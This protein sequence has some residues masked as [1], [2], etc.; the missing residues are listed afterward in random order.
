VANTPRDLA[1]RVDVVITMLSDPA[2]V[3]EVLE[4]ADGILSA[5][6]QGLTLIDMSTVGPLDAR[7]TVQRAAAHG[8]PVLHAS[9]LGPPAAA[10]EGKLTILVG[11]DATLI[12]RYHALLAAMGTAIHT[13]PT[14]EQACALKLAS[15]VQLL[16]ALQLFG[17][18][19]ALATG[20]GIPREA[21]LEFFQNS[22]VIAAPVKARI[23]AMYNPDLPANFALSLGRKDLWLAANAAYEAGAAVPMIASTLE[24]YSLAMREHH[25]EDIARI[26]GFIMEHSTI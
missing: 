20:W 14:N 11:G 12:A 15:N 7:D 26:A 18:G 3:R 4:G 10:A 2:A 24:S 1:A 22:A 16:A 17:E 6:H 9:V 21:V 25:D 23:G 8:V 5:A 19:V 13:F